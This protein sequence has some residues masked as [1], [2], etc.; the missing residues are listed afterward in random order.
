[1]KAYQREPKAPIQKEYDLDNN[2]DKAMFDDM[3]NETHFEL[4]KLLKNFANITPAKVL[5]HCDNTAYRED[6]N[7]YTDG[8]DATWLCG[9]CE[10]THRYEDH[11]NDCCKLDS[12]FC[13][14]CHTEHDTE[15]EAKDCCAENAA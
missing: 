3:L 12:W 10:K 13:G 4:T 7:N 9:E 8:L 2:E 1:M 15:D 5:E 14:E 11:A 6:F